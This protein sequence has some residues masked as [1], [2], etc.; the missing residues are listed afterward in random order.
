MT[1]DRPGT[2]GSPAD[3][4]RDPTHWNDRYRNSGPTGVSWF[5]PSADWS[6]A[7]VDQLQVAAETPTLDVGGGASM[8]IDG[9]L[10]RGFSDVT[11]LDVSGAGLEAARGRLGDSKA[12]HWIEQDLL[13]WAPDRQYGLWHDRAVFHFLVDED[14]RQL[15]RQLMTKALGAGGAFIIG[16]FADDGP[17]RCSGLP[18]TRYSS[19]ELASALGLQ[20][21]VLVNRRELH[22]T[23]AGVTQPFT[24]VA[25]R[26]PER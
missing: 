17:E 7:L 16:T 3:R 21:A 15:Y 14:G 20:S 24:W 12:A 25:G 26:L 22:I 18:V 19:S 4:Y 9:L 1:D 10:A 5:Q 6:L 2:G 11:V 13:Q 23:P 8:L